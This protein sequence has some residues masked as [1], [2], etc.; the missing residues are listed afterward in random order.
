MDGLLS[1]AMHDIFTFK[2]ALRMAG[3]FV[4]AVPL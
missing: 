1:V 3:R 4:V 2:W